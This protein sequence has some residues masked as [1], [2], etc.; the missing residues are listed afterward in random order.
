MLYLMSEEYSEG[1]ETDND[2]SSRGSSGRQAAGESEKIPSQDDPPDEPQV[3][4][5]TLWLTISSRLT[6]RIE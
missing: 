5:T 3:Q 4:D 2:P 6:L 1:G